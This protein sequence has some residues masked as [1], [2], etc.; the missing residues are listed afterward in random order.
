MQLIVSRPNSELKSIYD[1]C[2]HYQTSE[3]GELDIIQDGIVIATH[4]KGQ[5]DS[6]SR[7]KDEGESW[8]E[9]LLVG[10]EGDSEDDYEVENPIGLSVYGHGQGQKNPRATGVTSDTGVS[11]G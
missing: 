9:V 3:D 4:A 6:V 2:F 7:H 10:E 1:D 5:W 11:E 8:P